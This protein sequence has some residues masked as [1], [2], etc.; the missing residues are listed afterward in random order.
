MKDDVAKQAKAREQRRDR[1]RSTDVARH[2]ERDTVKDVI[3][4]PEAAIDANEVPPKTPAGPEL[5][6]PTSTEPSGTRETHLV[7][8]I[9]PSTSVEDVLGQGSR[10]S[11]RPR[12]AV[13][14][15]E[16]NLRDKMRRPT[17]ELVAAVAETAFQKASSVKAEGSRSE[18]EEPTGSGTEK[19]V[20][21]VVT[22]KREDG[23]GAAV[24]KSLPQAR[25]ELAADIPSPLEHRPKSQP[26]E[27]PSNV[28]MADRH[29]TSTPMD[30]E[31]AIARSRTSGNAISALVATNRRAKL[32]ASESANVNAG[33]EK[34]LDKLA[35]FDGPISSPQSDE[36]A[37][38][39]AADE[40]KSTSI[41]RHSRRHST[42]PA[43]PKQEQVHRSMSEKSIS[44][45][46]DRESASLKSSK[47]SILTDA[48]SGEGASRA[49]R[50]A[51]RRRSTLL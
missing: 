20:T 24:W 7:P 50:M 49:D 31:D 2:P 8:E 44:G 4:A 9:M 34:A 22:V 18:S 14:Y 43:G 15:A 5:F 3:A 21:R 11:R 33:L 12:S 23:P 19:P 25:L 51:S 46:R 10:P 30:T 48:T 28:L 27:P 35:I 37:A 16:P 1:A 45:G 39:K 41:S 40:K 42:N 26:A 38:K 36:P 17:K 47:S 13:S 29:R 6:S 32:N